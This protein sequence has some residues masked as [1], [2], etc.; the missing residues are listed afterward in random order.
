MRS[1]LLALTV[2]LVL[3]VPL[4]SQAHSNDGIDDYHFEVAWKS[5]NP[6]SAGVKFYDN[7]TKI[8]YAYGNQLKMLDAAT[9]QPLPF[10]YEFPIEIWDFI[11]VGDHA[12]LCAKDDLHQIDLK[13]GQVVRQFEVPK[14]SNGSEELSFQAREIIH[15]KSKKRLYLF[16]NNNFFPDDYRSLVMMYD[17]NSET[18]EK[19]AQKVPIDSTVIWTHAELSPDE[20]YLVMA[21][22]EPF[23]E[24]NLFQV[25]VYETTN[26]TL[27]W[28]FNA[29][30]PKTW[31]GIGIVQSMKFSPVNSDLIFSLGMEPNIL[32][33]DIY[34]K[35]IKNSFFPPDSWIANFAPLNTK[36]DVII[37]GKSTPN[38]ASIVDYVIKKQKILDIPHTEHDLAGSITITQ[39]DQYVIG[40]GGGRICKVKISPT[41]SVAFPRNDTTLIEIQNGVISLRQEQINNFTS[42]R[43]INTKGKIV[44]EKQL[45]LS[46]SLYLNMQSYPSGTYILSL[47]DNKGNN[48]IY[49][50]LWSK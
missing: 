33:A 43:L 13:T 9:G 37:S 18:P 36:A 34:S 31:D 38:K 25:K 47:Q 42:F 8:V 16:G 6:A 26:F 45:Q 39:D 15:S 19:V 27:H 22:K 50:F 17:L 30:D 2:A 14:I 1:Y 23:N 4:Y 3:T 40:T 41:N 5:S 24:L 35:N 11:V 7:E 28:K 29:Y 48:K 32:V 12:F 10:L 49:K 20:E 46:E 21:E 44:H